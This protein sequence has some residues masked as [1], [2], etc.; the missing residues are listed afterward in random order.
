MASFSGSNL[1]TEF[2]VQLCSCS[3][4]QSLWYYYSLAVSTCQ[5]V[6]A[7]S[8]TR[9]SVQHVVKSVTSVPSKA[10]YS[11]LRR[12]ASNGV[13]TFH[14]VEGVR[15]PQHTANGTTNLVTLPFDFAWQHYIM[16]VVLKANRMSMCRPRLLAAV[17]SERREG[18]TA[19]ADAARPDTSTACCAKANDHALCTYVRM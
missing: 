17:A 15:Y 19:T 13:C 16:Y 10:C 1:N 6:M 14:V 11:H 3:M 2:W 9:F 8:I 12:R 5:S 18:T 7:F 4:R